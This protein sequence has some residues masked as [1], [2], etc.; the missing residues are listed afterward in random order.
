MLGDILSCM[1]SL[2]CWAA[3]IGIFVTLSMLISYFSEDNEAE[4]NDHSYMMDKLHQNV[5]D[6]QRHSNSVDLNP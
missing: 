2:W 3:A 6:F 4:D 5:K 1:Y